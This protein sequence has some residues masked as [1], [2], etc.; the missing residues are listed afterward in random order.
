MDPKSGLCF[1]C[2]KP[3]HKTAE[4]PEPP[5]KPKPERAGFCVI[6]LVFGLEEESE[7]ENLTDVMAAVLKEH[8]VSRGMGMLDC[9]A[10]D[11]VG[12][13]EA[14]EALANRT[15]DRFGDDAVKV[16]PSV[17]PTYRFGNHQKEVCMSEVK[18]TVEPMGVASVLNIH[19]LPVPKAP[20]LIS[21]KSMGT[22]GAAINF[23][24]GRAIFHYLN[25]NKC[26]QLY[27]S[28]GG[29]LY[30]DFFDAM[31]EVDGGLK[32]LMDFSETAVKTS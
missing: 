29:H 4:C 8:V 13:Y 5:P 2:G 10:T 19:A 6:G 20:I 17:N 12:G 23:T 31:P 7:A 26:V 15:Q 9:G 24:T 21:V 3:G 30:V 1:R 27:R 18:A 25:P 22:L 32:A 14:V 28:A 11:T 16:D